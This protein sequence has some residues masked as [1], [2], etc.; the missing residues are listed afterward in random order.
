MV[1][2]GASKA[3]RW[4]KQLQDEAIYL[5]LQLLAQLQQ[6]ACRQAHKCECDAGSRLPA[7]LQSLYAECSRSECWY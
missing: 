4:S 3:H 2:L 6:L 7:G 5:V 1:S